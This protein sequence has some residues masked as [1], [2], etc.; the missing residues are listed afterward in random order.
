M[1]LIFGLFMIY[2]KIPCGIAQIKMKLASSAA[3]MK[4]PKNGVP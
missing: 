2:S 3:I 1:T 4:S